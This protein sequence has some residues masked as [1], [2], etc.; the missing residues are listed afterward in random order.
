VPSFSSDD[1]STS[2]RH[3]KNIEEQSTPDKAWGERAYLDRL[4]RYVRYALYPTNPLRGS[5][6]WSIEVLTHTKLK[7]ELPH[8]PTSCKPQNTHLDHNSGDNKI[9]FSISAS[10]SDNMIRR[11]KLEK[12]CSP[13]YK[14][15]LCP[16]KFGSMTSLLL[17]LNSCHSLFDCST[18]TRSHL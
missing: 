4:Y 8:C 15:L 16:D 12:I 14:G 1:A 5:Y 6:Q 18:C 3:P 17:L 7:H 10:R 9:L 13:T 2:R 11:Q